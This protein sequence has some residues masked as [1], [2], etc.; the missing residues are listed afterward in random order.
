MSDCVVYALQFESL[1]H[2]EEVWHSFHADPEWQE[3][4]ALPEDG[5]PV[6]LRF[7]STILKAT[8][9]SPQ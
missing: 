1:A 9:Y 3:Y 8:D 2:R 6:V 5:E 7:K 4:K